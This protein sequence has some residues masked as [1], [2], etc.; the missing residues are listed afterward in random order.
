[1]L[2]PEIFHLLLLLFCGAQI[3]LRY[4][5]FS[6]WAFTDEISLVVETTNINSSEERLVKILHWCRFPAE[7]APAI[8]GADQCLVSLRATP[9]TSTPTVHRDQWVWFSNTLSSV[10]ELVRELV[11]YC[12]ILLETK[13]S[14]K[15]KNS[16]HRSMAHFSQ[17]N[18]IPAQ[19][20]NFNSSWSLQPALPFSVQRRGNVP[21]Q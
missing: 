6:L 7:T 21:Y 17:H 8:R 4:M 13:I 19:Q 1:M 20:T 12:H 2:L 15:Q 11:K 9:L 10:W 3:C 18:K 16:K 5:L 14:V